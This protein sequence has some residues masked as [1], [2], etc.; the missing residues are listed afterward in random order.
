M[1]TTAA[2]IWESQLA[3]LRSPCPSTATE[4]TAQYKLLAQFYS[5][6]EMA[7]QG[8]GYQYWQ[9]ML[10]KEIE[11]RLDAILDLLAKEVEESRD[12]ALTK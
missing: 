4:L 5:E 2:P 6:V 9:V 12:L 11:A 10:M 3:V 7:D 1:S 8:A